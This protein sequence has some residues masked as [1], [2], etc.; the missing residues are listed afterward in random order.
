MSKKVDYKKQLPLLLKISAGVSVLAAIA[1]GIFVQN[2]SFQLLVG[3]LAKDPLASTDKTV[4]VPAVHAFF[5][6]QLR[7]LVVAYF[8]VTAV[9]PVLAVTKFSARYQKSLKSKVM[10]YRWVDWAILTLLVVSSG[11]LLAGVQDVAVL[12]FSKVAILVAAALLWQ[13]E[14]A[15]SKN[16][17]PSS[18]L[19]GLAMVLAAAPL[20]I[21]LDQLSLTPFYS[22]IRASWYVYAVYATG[23]ISVLAVGMNHLRTLRS[24]QQWK[25]YSFSE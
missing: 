20:L 13:S 25:D 21:M 12:G 16:K 15:A 8:A 18:W 6:V 11:L 2:V 14:L 7:W 1:V 23:V 9:I 4:I 24:F 10:M 17:K 19:F 22:G 3:H 5:D